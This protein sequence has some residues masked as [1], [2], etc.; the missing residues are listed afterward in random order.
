MSM[1][2]K[3]S[4]YS[5]HNGA[6]SGETVGEL[7]DQ[8]ALLSGKKV[9]IVG[10][11]GLDEYIMGEVHRIS[12]EAPVPILEVSGE[13][14][15][16]GMSANVAQNVVSLGGQPVLISV[17]GVDAGAQKLRE[18]LKKEGVDDSHLIE[19]SRR[20][21][22]RKARVMTGHNHIVRVDY[23]HRHDID[24]E[25]EV[26]VLNSVKSQLSHCD[27][28]VLQ[29]YAKGLLSENTIQQILSIAKDSGREVL[30]DP[31]RSTP[32]SFYRGAS[33]FKPNLQ[34]SLALLGESFDSCRGDEEATFQLGQRIREQLR[35]QEVVLT[36]GSEGMVLYDEGQAHWVPTYARQVFDVTGAGDTVI[37]TLALAKAAG[38]SLLESCVLANFAAGYVVGQVGCVPCSSENLHSYINSRKSSE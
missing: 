28:V 3:N 33:L 8:I 30:I 25:V 21:T 16:L 11:S 10:D 9:M 7:S 15:R 35:A 6:M 19:D 22:T 20:P 2:N 14:C 13:D 36:R 26:K 18:A 12:P 34:E 17:V 23:E 1:L 37:A 31:H 38:L 29:D 27:V 24:R 4:K 32:L 5:L